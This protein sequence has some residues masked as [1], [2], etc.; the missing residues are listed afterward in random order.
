M[1]VLTLSEREDVFNKVREQ[2]LTHSEPAEVRGQ[3]D[4]GEPE[5]PHKKPRLQDTDEFDDDDN[6]ET[7]EQDELTQDQSSKLGQYTYILH[8]WKDNESKL[9]H[10]AKSILCMQAS[11][12]PSERNFSIQIVQANGDVV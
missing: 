2:L 7:Q 9:A 3:Y 10:L 6:N 8:W 5:P 1:N 11:S 12:A 4:T